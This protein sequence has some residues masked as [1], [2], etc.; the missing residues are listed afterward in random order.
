[1]RQRRPLTKTHLFCGCCRGVAA[2]EL[3]LIVPL[4]LLMGLALFDFGEAIYT[5]TEVQNAAQAG[6]QYAVAHGFDANS[7]SAA[8]QAATNF[9]SVSASP[10]PN[11]FCGCATNSGVSQ[12]SCNSKCTDGSAPGTYVT[13][14]ALG[15]YQTMIPYP[16]L[17]KSFS[18]SAQ[19]TVRIQ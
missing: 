4:L 19:S 9:A 15:S 10:A 16:T 2:V 5:K 17:P 12:I 1:M 3:A 7:V 18:F 6:A 8:V 14:S 13:V 11:Q